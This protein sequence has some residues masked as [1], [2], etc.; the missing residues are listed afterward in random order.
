M[1]KRYF[2][3]EVFYEDMKVSG[4]GL[5]E[6][7]L[8]GVSA[9]H[10]CVIACGRV[11]RLEDG[12]KRKGPE[13]ETLVGFGPN[14]WLN[15][16]VIATRMGELCDRF[17]L[18]TI[19]MSNTI[20]LA[21][22]LY[23]LGRITEK[24]TDGLK[25][26]WGN[27]AVLEPLIRQTV[28]RQGFG[29]YLAQGSRQLGRRYGAEEEAVQVNG[30]EVAYHDPRGASGMALVYATSPRGACHNQSDYFL[31][32][33]GQVEPSLGMS[34]F[35]RHDGAEKAANVAAHQD[36]RTVFNALVLCF[37]SNVPPETVLDLINSALGYEWTLTDMLQTG[38]RAWNL[39]R[40]INNRL[41]LNR[42]NDKLPR[43]LLRDYLDTRLPGGFVPEFDAM[44]E[45][46]YTARGWDPITGFPTRD[47]LAGLG[48]DWVIKDLYPQ[49]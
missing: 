32:D 33:V 23:E 12:E 16:P 24:D 6:T 19:S 20:G 11:V 39:K 28:A 1:P 22:R 43:P 40:A 27:A 47:K 10:A 42:S 13:Y 9:C 49:A 15:D 37:F 2:Q 8:A 36:W 48:L 35:S 5:K 29:S 7:I 18:D 14:L 46:Y 44:L 45:A 41:G 17:G 30:L 4:A 25:L 38:E 3:N 34:F 21:F 26:D 31:V